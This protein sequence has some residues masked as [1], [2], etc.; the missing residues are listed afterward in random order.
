MS[1]GDPSLIE[2]GLTAT[3]QYAMRKVEGLRT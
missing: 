1:V 3:N 2:L